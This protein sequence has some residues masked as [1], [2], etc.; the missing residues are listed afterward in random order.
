MIELSEMRWSSICARFMNLTSF[1]TTPIYPDCVIFT[2]WVVSRNDCICFC[3][4]RDK[5]W[6]QFWIDAEYGHVE[7]VVYMDGFF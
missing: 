1:S 4:P 5:A 2:I 3:R 6:T 7:N